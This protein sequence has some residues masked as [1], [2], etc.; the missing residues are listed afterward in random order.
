M[1][2]T[3]CA[4]KGFQSETPE[5]PK[6][7]T[8]TIWFDDIGEPLPLSDEDQKILI[9]VAWDAVA[10]SIDSNENIDLISKL[11]IE[12]I[13]DNQP[14]IIFISISDAQSAAKVILGQGKGLISALEDAI[15]KSRGFVNQNFQPKWL[16][17]DIVGD[18]SKIKNRGSAFELERS[19]Y[20]L[21]M[22]RNL[23]LAFLPEELVASSIIDS[24]QILRTNYLADYLSERGN[25]YGGVS[26]SILVIEAETEF[27][28][29]KTISQ[30][31]DGSVTKA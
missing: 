28:R 31:T 18:V 16:K 27:F 8:K 17:M 2:L 30:F 26:P 22:P 24:N 14:R 4:F 5:E 6:K 15:Q 20:G 7:P 11:P 21:A 19:L 3:G 13:G 9:Q 1:S 23:K 12:Y 10:N 29:F 25:Q